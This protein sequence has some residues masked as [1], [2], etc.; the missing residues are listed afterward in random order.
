MPG[1]TAT[2]KPLYAHLPSDTG[3][4]NS[5]FFL[6]VPGACVIGKSASEGMDLEGDG[7]HEDH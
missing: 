6:T 3:G 7:F 2:P 5:V 4:S 1:G